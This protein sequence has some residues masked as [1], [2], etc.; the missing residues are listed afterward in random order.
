MAYLPSVLLLMITRSYTGIALTMISIGLAAGIFK[1]LI[2]GTIRAVT[3]SSNKTLGFGIF[4]NM[5]NIGATLGPLIAAKLRAISWNNAFLAGAI[6]IGIMLLITVFFY[7][8]PP[9][10]TEGKT[11]REKFGD[12]GQAL[13][14]RRFLVFLV[15]LG[16]FFWAPFWAFFS[17][18]AMYADSQLN[19]VLLYENIRSV[20]GPFIASLISQEDQGVRK[21]LG[22]SIAN[23]AYYIILFQLVVSNIVK[24]FRAIPAF[25]AGIFIIGA[26]YFCMGLAKNMAPAW[27]LLGVFLFAVG[28]MTSSP[29]IQE[30]ITWLAPKEKAGLYMGTNFLAMGIGSSL[31]GFVMTPLYGFFEQHHKPENMWFFLAGTMLLAMIVINLYMKLFGNFRELD[32]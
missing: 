9:R 16:L 2:S 5:V 8:D 13:A 27:F 14:D 15:I 11:L 17:A 22:E 4:Y 24:K 18:A 30:Y 19:T 26:G 3:H 25:T 12:M 31:S 32:K 21:V 29:R 20:L 28:E 7:K 1:P 10:E 6:S 23:S